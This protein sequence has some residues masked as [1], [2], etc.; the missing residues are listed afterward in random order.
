M[1]HMKKRT[2]SSCPVALSLD[3]LGDKWSLVI[4]RDIL[5]GGKSHFR[6]FLTSDEKISTNILSARLESLIYDGF[7]TKHDDESNKSAAIYRPTQKSLDLLPMLFEY[8]KW[9]VRY[10]TADATIPGVRMVLEEPETI[11]TMVLERFAV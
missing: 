2:M 10:T 4:L 3:L 7:L 5:L 6:E 8:M 9:G 11:K 1:M